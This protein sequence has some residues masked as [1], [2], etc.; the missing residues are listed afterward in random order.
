VPNI[1]GYDP[2]GNKRP[3]RKVRREPPDPQSILAS[4]PPE[5]QEAMANSYKE[6][7][8]RFPIKGIEAETAEAEKNQEETAKDAASKVEGAPKKGP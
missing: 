4:L 7:L 3:I 5:A 8:A 6:Q 2:F 1:F